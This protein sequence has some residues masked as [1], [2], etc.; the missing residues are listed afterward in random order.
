M[1]S[2]PFENFKNQ[3]KEKEFT[4]EKFYKKYENFFRKYKKMFRYIQENYDLEADTLLEDLENNIDEIMNDENYYG[5]GL[6]LNP[7][8][9]KALEE[10]NDI[11]EDLM[12]GEIEM[13]EEEYEAFQEKYKYLDKVAYL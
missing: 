2:D 1:S 13:T 4:L 10:Y 6:Q 12:E 9:E 3:L 11:L 5:G 7:D 8:H